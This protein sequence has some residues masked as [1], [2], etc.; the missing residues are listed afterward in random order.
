MPGE[1]IGKVESSESLRM[2]AISGKIATA[3]RLKLYAAV[4]SNTPSICL[5]WSA[6]LE[7]TLEAWA[8][9]FGAG[10]I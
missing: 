7:L 9:I 2:M 10:E 6:S 5:A 1:R 3:S 4:R 8:S